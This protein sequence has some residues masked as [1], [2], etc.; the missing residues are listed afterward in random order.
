M[1][2]APIVRSPSSAAICKHCGAVFS[3][4]EFSRKVIRHRQ[5]EGLFQFFY[6]YR[7]SNLL[8]P[9]A[10]LVTCVFLCCC[11]LAEVSFCKVWAG[12][13]GRSPPMR[14]LLGWGGRGRCLHDRYTVLPV[15]LRQQ[16]GCRRSEGGPGHICGQDLGHLQ[17]G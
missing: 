5:T 8:V 6:F 7:P 4:A 9:V 11:A 13:A 1:I 12:S 2:K 16:A 10:G 14:A 15:V 3:A 17:V